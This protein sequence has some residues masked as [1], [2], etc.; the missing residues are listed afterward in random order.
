[1]LRVRLVIVE[2]AGCRGFGG[3]CCRISNTVLSGFAGTAGSP[4]LSVIG[5]TP[6]NIVEILGLIR[7]L[8]RKDA[9]LI[10]FIIGFVPVNDRIS[11]AGCPAIPQG[12]LLLR[13]GK[14][15][16]RHVLIELLR[17]LRG[18]AFSKS[19]DQVVVVLGSRP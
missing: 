9:G 1:M 13:Q 15:L 19:E 5:L 8:P 14:L 10:V 17:L 3:G 6:A 18:D 2:R 11:T 4:N 12:K 16:L 7:R